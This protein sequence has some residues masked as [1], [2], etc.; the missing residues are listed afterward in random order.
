MKK[1]VCFFA[2]TLLISSI[3]L[4]Q[5]VGIGTATPN[6]SAALEVSSNK[7]GVLLSRMTSL[8]RKAIASP[9]AGLLVF[10]TDK[11]SLYMFNGQQ[12]QPLAF[13]TQNNMPP[14]E[15]LPDSVK[16]YDHVGFSVDIKGDVAVTGAPGDTINGAGFRG[17][18][19]VYERINGNW[20]QTARLLASDGLAGDQFGYAVAVSGDYIAV[21]ANFD[22]SSTP[23]VATAHGSV[24]IFHKVGGVWTEEFKL[25]AADYASNDQFGHSI[26]LDN[27]RLMV[28]S[29]FDNSGATFCGSVYFYQRSGVSWNQ[30][31]KFF[32]AGFTASEQF[33]YSVA[34]RGDYAIAGAP[35]ADPAGVNSAGSVA[36]YVFGGGT[37][38]LQTTINGTVTA[39]RTGQSVDI[40]DT[41]AVVGTPGSMSNTGWVR[42]YKR[43]GS[44]WNAL[45]GIN[46]P[47]PET[48]A[49]FG[50]SV[51]MSGPYV[52][53]GRE[54]DG[55]N[56][57]YLFK[58]AP[59]GNTWDFVRE[60]SFS[61]PAISYPN[62]QLGYF[63]PDKNM[64]A[65][66]GEHCIFGHS[67]L[68]LNGG[69]SGALLFLNV[70][71]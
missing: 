13:V 30:V 38:N 43:T 58:L 7:L 34:L 24:Y 19:Y 68:G 33:G 15:R 22:D 6:S 23:T 40:D 36:I 17:S 3:L 71:D 69:E 56:T 37:W 27:D 25:R 10:D 70:G 67:W 5:S 63:F 62:P 28:G 64:V 42:T 57:S 1:M 20:T 32:R 29:P 9:V 14:T 4:S 45:L 51:S 21:S 35:F 41:Y 16:T 26:A 47:T 2:L 18:A 52:M 44:T 60:I 54:L 50:L 39:Y 59:S 31:N 61:R 46:M 11:S 8:E 49:F 12:W 66:D 53:V 48:G 55:S 65:I